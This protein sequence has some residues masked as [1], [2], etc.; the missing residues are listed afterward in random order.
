MGAILE[1]IKVKKGKLK[2]FFIGGMVYNTKFSFDTGSKNTY[3]FT[4][5]YLFKIPDKFEDGIRYRSLVYCKLPLICLQFE[6][7][8]KCIEF[9]FRET[10]PF[11]GLKEM[12][13]Y[14]EIIFKH[15]PEITIKEKKN[16]WLGFPRKKNIKLPF[17]KARFRVRVYEKKS[18]KDA[19]NDFFQRQNFDT[20]VP[21][22]NNLMKGVKEALFRSYDNELGIFLQMPWVNSTGFCM[23]KYSYSLMGFEAKRLNYFYEL[24][25]K[26]GDPD[27]MMWCKKLESLFL[28]P[29]LYKK[30]KNGL[31]WYNLT[32]FNGK[33]LEGMFYLDIGY[34]GYPPGQATISYNLG[35]YL[36]KRENDNLKNLLKENLEYIFNTQ[37]SDGSWQSALPYKK[38][39]VRK[40]RKSEGSTAECVKALLQGFKIFYEEKYKESAL[41]GLKFLER[42]NIICKN[43]L[44]DIGIDEPEAFS[45]I[46]AAEA[47][48]DA[49]DLFKNKEYL[50]MAEKYAYHMLT[51]HYWYGKQKG[52]FHPISESI[53]PRI[54]PFESLMA[55]KVYKKLYE[56]TSNVLWNKISDFLFSRVLKVLDRNNGLSEGIFITP[57]G[58]FSP[59]PMEQTFATAE[60]LHT[61]LLYTAYIHK[62]QNKEPLKI[63]EEGGIVIEDMVKIS[64]EIKINDKELKILLSDPYSVVSKFYR[65]ASLLLRKFGFLNS[66]RDIRYLFRGVAPPRKKC[67]YMRPLNLSE[68]EITKKE[69]EVTI[70]KS[71]PF[72]DIKITFYKSK[73]MKMDVEIRIKEHDLRCEKVIINGKDYTL[74]T[75]WTNGGLFKKTIDL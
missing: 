57:N 73:K 12:E 8:C 36:E 75:N 31:V 52:F 66:A 37:N 62:A 59:L 58:E 15:F 50:G 27:Y 47:F 55:I 67:K 14:Y 35:K 21:D 53:T 34:A 3:P 45:A 13:D 39:P 60:L 24:Y 65:K 17:G 46:L 22:V 74:D 51:W 61:C 71:F 30:T 70:Y 33:E 64:K 19:V 29:K 2:H 1:T 11:V 38:I 9:E 68:C 43:V 20:I 5:Y 16:A 48:L 49:Y 69:N 42:E 63:R 18:W 41:R 40:W 6:N 28:N 7:Y 44:R 26:T 25:E 32:H 72:H 4:T 56:K 23:D 10:L 54:S